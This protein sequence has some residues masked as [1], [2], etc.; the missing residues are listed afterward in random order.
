MIDKREGSVLESQDGTTEFAQIAASLNGSNPQ[1]D[2]LIDA[3]GTAAARADVVAGT[4][5]HGSKGIRTTHP[6]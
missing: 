6:W 5:L 4:P 2:T 3:A 1:S